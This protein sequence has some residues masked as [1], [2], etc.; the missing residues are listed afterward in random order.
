MVKTFDRVIAHW[1]NTNGELG[2]MEEMEGDGWQ[3]NNTDRTV[4]VRVRISGA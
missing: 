4:A 3:R 1:R 2:Q